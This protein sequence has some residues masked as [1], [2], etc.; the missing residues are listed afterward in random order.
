MSFHAALDTATAHAAFAVAEA[1]GLTRLETCF[2]ATGQ[3]AAD[4]VPALIACLD[5]HHIPLNAIRRWTVGMGPGSF[6][7]IRTGAAFVKGLCAANGAACRGLPTSLALAL[8]ADDSAATI[9]A[10]HDGRREEAIATRYRRQRH[11]LVADGTPTAIPLT[12]LNTM[13][14][15]RFVILAED[16]LLPQLPPEVAARTTVLPHLAA[17]HLLTPPGWPWPDSP[18]N[19]A[20]SLEPIYVRPPVFVPPRPTDTPGQR[21]AQL[22]Q[23]AP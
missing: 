17:T 5:A 2:D 21:L 18:A 15:D 23:P 10:L 9:V 4:L 1:T 11:A 8:A 12:D 20:A 22:A 3:A 6:T 7:G 19:V 13:P 16:R 14:A